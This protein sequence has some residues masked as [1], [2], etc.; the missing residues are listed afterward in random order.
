MHDFHL[1]NQI[2]MVAKANAQK[3]KLLKINKIVI[4]LGEIIEHGENITPENL[5]YNINLI[6]PC[7]VEVKKVKGDK[8]RLIS[9]EGN[10]I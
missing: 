3:N 2:V 4:E 9:I 6:L 7:E 5:A 10:K 1:A 8:W